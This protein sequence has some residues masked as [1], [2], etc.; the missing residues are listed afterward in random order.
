[1][2]LLTGSK[3]GIGVRSRNSGIWGLFRIGWLCYNLSGAWNENGKKEESAL[4]FAEKLDHT[5]E[6]VFEWERDKSL[7]LLPKK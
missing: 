3:G 4:S 7:D 5:I 2:M 1:M 6:D